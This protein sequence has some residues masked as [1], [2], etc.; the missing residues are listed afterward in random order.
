MMRKPVSGSDKNQ[1]VQQQK[2]VRG[3]QFP[4]KEVEKLYYLCSENKDAD[5]LHGFYAADLCFLCIFL[6]MQKAGFL[7]T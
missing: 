4:I 1:A 3:L 5:Q 6:H 2:T 7:M